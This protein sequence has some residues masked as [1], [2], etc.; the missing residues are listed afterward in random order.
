MDKKNV[1]KLLQKLWNFYE[2]NDYNGP[3]ENHKEFI[4]AA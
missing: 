2:K 3:P 4:Y 1:N